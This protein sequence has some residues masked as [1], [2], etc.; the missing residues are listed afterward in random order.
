MASSLKHSA[1]AF[2][3]AFAALVTLVPTEVRADTIR[4]PTLTDDDF[5]DLAKEFSALTSWRSVT[6]P[7]SMGSIFGFE[8][9]LVAGITRTPAVDRLVKQ[10][11]ATS[12]VPS[13][14]FGSLLGAIT[15]PMTGLTVEVLYI[16]K[17]SGGSA[18]FQSM[19]GALKWGLSDALFPVSPVRV[20][21]RGFVTKTDLTYVQPFSQGG[22]TVDGTV[23]FSNQVTGVQVL[24]SPALL[25][26]I[27][28]YVGLGYL[29]SK[30]EGSISGTTSTLFPGGSQ[31]YSKSPTSTQFL[32]GL[33][34][35]LLILAFGL[36]WSKAY[37]TD[38]YSG[39][40]TFKF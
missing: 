10:A 30:S 36:E 22:F 11:S 9:G 5:N 38:S 26:V 31:S 16:P 6:P 17:V 27:E 7:S 3:L 18:D 37:G 21:A 19:G 28:P 23:K 20:A 24:A 29:M 35:R 2:V 33:E 39:K 1:M 4:L 34:V 14:P 40:F 15:I 12:S 32:L 25:P 8:F 13:L